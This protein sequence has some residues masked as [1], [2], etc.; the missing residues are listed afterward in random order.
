MLGWPAFYPLHPIT[1]I[2]DPRVPPKIGSNVGSPCLGRKLR[3][4]VG[5]QERLLDHRSQQGPASPA[6]LV[7]WKIIL[8]QLRPFWVISPTFCPI[9]PGSGETPTVSLYLQFSQ[10]ARRTVSR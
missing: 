3:G 5:F 8:G 9:S 1:F 6:L 2:H 4:A 10:Q 7:A